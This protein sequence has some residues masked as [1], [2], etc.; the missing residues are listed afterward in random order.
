MKPF[1]LTGNI[2]NGKSTVAK[3]LARNEDVKVLDCDSIAKDIIANHPFR[4]EVAALLETD[5]Y[6]QGVVDFK[7]IARVIFSDVAKKK[8]FEKLLHP[9]VWKAVREGLER[10]PKP[11]EI[12]ET[13]ILFE[14]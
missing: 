11:I 8:A 13:A 4:A 3:M 7:T 10:D 12:V 14:T 6:P 1:G 5:P 9:L 2:C